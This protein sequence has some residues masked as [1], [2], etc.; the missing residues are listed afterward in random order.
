VLLFPT[1]W[2]ESFGL[3]VREA[4]AR[5]VW[6]ITTDAGGVVEDIKPGRNGYIIPFLDTG[7]ALKQAVIDTLEHFNTAKPGHELALGSLE[8]TFFEEQAAELT[9]IFKYVDAGDSV[10]I[11]NMS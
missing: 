8:I 7:E 1:Q 10:R 5:N 2:K 9:N 4:L 11:A 3:T 6:V